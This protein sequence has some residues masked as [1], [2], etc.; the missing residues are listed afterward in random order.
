MMMPSVYKY[1]NPSGLACLMLII[2]LFIRTIV[3][4]TLV[5][6][7]ETNGSQLATD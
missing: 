7:L 1:H 6:G 5:A 2:I 3:I 4:F